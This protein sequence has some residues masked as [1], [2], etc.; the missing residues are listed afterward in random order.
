M[1]TREHGV[2]VITRERDMGWDANW[3]QAERQLYY[4]PTVVLPL[5]LALPLA[6]TQAE[7]Q[8]YYNP[9]VVLLDPDGGMRLV[10]NLSG[11]SPSQ[12]LGQVLR[13][14][15]VAVPS[16]SETISFAE[17]EANMQA[18]Y[19]PNPN[20][21]PNASPHPHPSPHPNMQALY[22]ENVAWENTLTLALTPTCRRCTMRTSRGRRCSRRT[23]RCASPHARG[24]TACSL[25]RRRPTRCS[26]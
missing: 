14:L 9:S 24:S 22:N 8:L 13:Q 6:L 10:E 2:G 7:R 1:I 26:P 17:A 20:P 16:E 3:L 18:L 25:A 4:N 5:P 19:N 15:H 11:L 23:T 21:N 12:V